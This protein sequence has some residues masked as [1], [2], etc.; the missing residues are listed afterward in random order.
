MEPHSTS[1]SHK[2]TTLGDRQ[3]DK[4]V[5]QVTCNNLTRH[6]NHK[7]LDPCGMHM[8]LSI[9]TTCCKAR[10]KPMHVYVKPELD[11]KVAL[12]VLLQCI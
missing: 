10:I 9:C 4:P 1:R 5:K 12:V 2:S 7:M 6:F 8:T 3:A 11:L